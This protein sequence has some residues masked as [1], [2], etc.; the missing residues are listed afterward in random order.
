MTTASSES[1]PAERAKIAPSVPSLD[2]DQI[3][4]IVAAEIALAA[5]DAD[6][7]PLDTRPRLR[8]YLHLFAFAAALIQAAVLIPLAAGQSGKAA[9]ATSIYCFFMCLMFGTSALY[10]RRRWTTRG[11]KIMKRMDHCMIFLFISGSYTPFALLAIPSPTR[12]WVLGVAWSGA[13]A[14]IIL[15]LFWPTSP[16]WVGVPIYIAI[17]WVALFV[18]VP[19]GTN[20]GAG[21]LVLMLVGGLFY[22]V[23]AV[24]YATKWPN[25]RPGVFGYH[26]VFH[27][28]VILAAVCHYIAV[29]LVLYHSPLVG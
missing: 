27:A 29:F 16:R 17:G 20:G 5:N 2:E 22:S 6:Y 9:L 1:K 24:F 7:E 19:I 10:H 23:G 12:W 14:G 15:K 3:A 11:W 8:G 28:F 26:E 13:L 18:L 25:I 21:A 4:A